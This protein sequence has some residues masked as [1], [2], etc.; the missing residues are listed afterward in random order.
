MSL[1]RQSPTMPVLA[2]SPETLRRILDHREPVASRPFSDR[3]HVTRN[4][5]DVGNYDLWKRAARG[6][7]RPSFRA[8]AS[9]DILREHGRCRRNRSSRRSNAHSLRLRQTCSGFPHDIA[10][11][12]TES[13][14]R[15][16]QRTRG[17]VNRHRMRPRQW[18][19]SACSKAGT[20]GPVGEEVRAKHSD[21]AACLRH[22]GTDGRRE[23]CE[24]TAIEFANIRNSSKSFLIRSRLVLKSGN[25]VSSHVP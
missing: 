16:V 1:W 20:S 8:N 14:A 4:T 6:G 19:V 13:Q 2:S 12:D 25:H 10:N 22:R 9:T 3:P 11:A 17:T 18:S 23:S 15:K 21:D 7:D 5:G 24:R